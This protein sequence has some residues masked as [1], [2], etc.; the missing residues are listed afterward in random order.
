MLVNS[1][2]SKCAVVTLQTFERSCFG[3]FDMTF[4]QYILY[5]KFFKIAFEAVLFFHGNSAHNGEI[6]TQFGIWLFIKLLQNRDF[7]CNY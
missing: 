5:R 6:C 7:S 4:G 3:N 1:R 2:V